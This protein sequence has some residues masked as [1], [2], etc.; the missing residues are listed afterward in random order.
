MAL[1]VSLGVLLALCLAGQCSAATAPPWICP[2][3]EKAWREHWDP[4]HAPTFVDVTV[5]LAYGVNDFH[6][7]HQKQLAS[8]IAHVAAVENEDWRVAISSVAE[9][10][11][12]IAV[13]VRIRVPPFEAV[14]VADRAVSIRDA[15]TLEQ[16]NQQR[17]LEPDSLEAITAVLVAAA[18]IKTE[19]AAAGFFNASV[20]RYPSSYS[21][22]ATYET[23]SLTP[24]SGYANGVS[25]F[26][27]IDVTSSMGK[28]VT[29]DWKYWGGVLGPD[30]LV[31]FV[32]YNL[33]D[34]GVLDPSTQSFTMIDI[35]STISG[36]NVNN[37]YGGGVLGPDGLIYF[38][39]YNADNIGVL[40]PSTQSFTVIDIA[41]TISEGD[42]SYFGGVLGPDGLIYFVP[43]YVPH[44]GVLDPS[45]Q[46]FTV[47]DIT[48]VYIAGVYEYWGGVLGPDGLIY[49]VP[50][51]ADNIGVLDPSTQSFTVIDIASIISVDEKY[52]AGVLG[53]DGLIYFVPYYADNIGVLDPSTQSF[54][55]IDIA[56]TISV[57]EKYSGGV[58]GPNGLIYFVPYSADNIG[59]LDPSTQSFT[60]IDIASTISGKVVSEASKYGGGVLGP[61]GR[62]YFVP[63]MAENIGMLEPG[64]TE[65]AYTVAGGVPEAWSAVLSPHFNKF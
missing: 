34:I 6:D 60:V 40:D 16:I 39:P 33:D 59:V 1:R 18:I 17:A 54:T 46:S 55:V 41:S 3:H 38:V 32:P 23:R 56:S 22:P 7:D 53:P 13:A 26:T 48:A 20:L 10:S 2:C 62:I 24:V 63:T 47:I 5:A 36:G 51:H 31:Y 64:N 35:S 12:G 49:F 58:L 9:A 27:D 8:V 44:I 37:E 45:T 61:N 30:G 43:Y 14:P 42:G 57:D 4:A 11:G 25:T 65:P 50:S 15:L 29:L 21:Y 19:T 52:A 28:M